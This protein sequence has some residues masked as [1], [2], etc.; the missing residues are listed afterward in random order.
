MRFASRVALVTGAGDG[1]GR[2]TA[3]L[4]AREGA[5]AAAL[6]EVLRAQ[7]EGIGA[8]RG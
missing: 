5:A 8:V 7:P 3:L 6:D 2:A 4:L 1:I